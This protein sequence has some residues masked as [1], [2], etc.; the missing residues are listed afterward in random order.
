V[1]KAKRK[2]PATA[3]PETGDRM[4]RD[5]RQTGIYQRVRDGRTTWVARFWHEGREHWESAPTRALAIALRGKR[6]HEA[7][8]GRILPGKVKPSTMTVR[9]LGAKFLAEWA[10][11]RKR[12]AERDR[13]VLRLHINPRL[14]GKLVRE[15]VALDVERYARKRLGEPYRQTEKSEP[16][17]TTAGTVNREIAL[18]K[19]MF[20]KA[21]DWSII[22]KNPLRKFRLLEEPEGRK[23][24]LEPEA[25]ARLLAACAPRLRAVVT[26]AL[27]TGLRQ[28]ELL[29][30]TW[31]A[32]DFRRGELTVTRLKRR[33]RVTEQIPMNGTARATLERLEQ[34]ATVGT[35]RPAADALVF[36]TRTGLAYANIRRDFHLAAVAACL[37][38]MRFHDCRHVY[39][40]RMVEQGADLR[41][42]QELLGHRT[43]RMVERYTHTTDERKRALVERLDAPGEG[44]A[45]EAPTVAE[46]VA[47]EPPNLSSVR[48]GK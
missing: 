12:T 40:S 24:R 17:P 36:G 43:L 44:D 14:G 15:L 2:R 8:E 1:G 22:G 26:L 23:P 34:A 31:E 7:A 13:R 38:G 46:T 41:S 33:Q 47:K 19:S 16:K 4:I 6:K 11:T 29:G 42:V 39:A 20:N 32:V 37:P 28:S 3:K 48:G 27:H 25:E 10:T 18:L 21:L 45:T 30:L 35:E 5:S 9:Q